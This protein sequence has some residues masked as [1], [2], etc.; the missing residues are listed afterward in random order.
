MNFIFMKKLGWKICKLREFRNYT[1]EF[2]AAQ[3]Q[4][5]QRSYSRIEKDLVRIRID[6][7]NK[8]AD[9]LGIHIQDI[10]SFDEK[11]LFEAPVVPAEPDKLIRLYERILEMNKQELEAKDREI[12][13][14]RRTIRSGQ[15]R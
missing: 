4:I 7:L 1:Q 9:I 2:M 14:L 11:K 8:I 15:E 10:L 6:H 12:E 5:S 3:L 13:S